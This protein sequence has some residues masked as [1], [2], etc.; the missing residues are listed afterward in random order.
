LDEGRVA[1]I[2]VKLGGSV[3]TDKSS[4]FTYRGEAVLRLAREMVLS[5][6]RVVVVHGGGSF[7]HTAARKYGLS[8]RAPR[9]SAA[10]VG[11]TRAAMYRLNLLVCSSLAEAGMNPYSFS[12]FDLLL[13]AG[14]PAS[15]I[16]VLLNA[17][18]AP[19]TF[20]DVVHD[21]S[22]FRILS[23]D[24]IAYELCRLL[25]PAR[26]IFVLDAEGIYDEEG[27]LIAELA[28]SRIGRLKLGRA[29]DATGGI[30]LKLKEASRIAALG[31]ETAF[32]SGK[33]SAEFAKAL[34]MVSFHGTI[35]RVRRSVQA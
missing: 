23:G 26:C 20:G 5:G 29:D 8:S 22:G 19:V 15:W 12:P 30:R 4:P 3:V 35:V 7:G 33:S 32:V 28:T 17:G 6:R 24:T 1:P 16:R 31:V 10:G 9:R 34:K 13:K 25:H 27:R 18:L 21:G 2:V 11:E 14:G